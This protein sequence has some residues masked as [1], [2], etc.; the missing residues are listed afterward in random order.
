MLKIGY[1]HREGEGILEENFLRVEVDISPKTSP[2]TPTGDECNS[3]L[4]HVHLSLLAPVLR[5]V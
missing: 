2:K 1:Q 5:P 3:V 4:A